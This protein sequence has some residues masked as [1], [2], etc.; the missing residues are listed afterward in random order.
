M[1]TGIIENTKFSFKVLSFYFKKLYISLLSFFLIF[2]YS[3]S[4][5]P[6]PI[7]FF[8]LYSASEYIYILSEQSQC[9][10]TDDTVKATD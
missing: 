5:Y 7:S 10:D 6:F 2:P 9:C 8:F 4:L 1:L 3:L